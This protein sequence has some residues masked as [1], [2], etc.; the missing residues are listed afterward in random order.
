MWDLKIAHLSISF[1]DKSELQTILTNVTEMLTAS[2][3]SFARFI[4][5]RW[6]LLFLSNQDA[7][8]KGRSAM[9]NVQ[10]TIRNVQCEPCNVQCPFSMYNAQCAKCNVEQLSPFLFVQS[11]GSVYGTM[12]VGTEGT[13]QQ[14]L[15]LDTWYVLSFCL[16]LFVCDN[17]PRSQ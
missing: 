1:C 15:Q 7:V 10:C 8:C 9:C 3:A 14:S 11:R 13:R 6:V 17:E 4:L 5:H 2:C 12:Y 16:C